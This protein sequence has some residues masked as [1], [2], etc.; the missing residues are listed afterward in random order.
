MGLW[1]LIKQLNWVDIFVL[2]LLF[3]TT[4]IAIKSGIFIEFFKLLGTLLGCFIS[5]HYFTKL[6]D[7]FE[8]C[9]PTPPTMPLEI[10]D[11][12]SFFILI[13][14]SYFIFFILREAFSKF[15]KTEVVTILNRWGAALLGI[16]RGFILVSL[17][18]FLLSIPVL[19]YFVNS[20]KDSFSGK[21]MIKVSPTVYAYSWKNFFS[22]F[23]PKQEYNKVVL[24]IQDDIL[25]Q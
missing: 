14:L 20:V 19:N 3:R 18:I 4:Y 16:T 13:I 7:F 2:I 17:I 6:G 12:F 22:K 10:W 9:I 5:L 15:V 11:F 23:M 24:E 21:R 1:K 8:A 25:K